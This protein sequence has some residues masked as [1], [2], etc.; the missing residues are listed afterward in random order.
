MRPWPPA[1]GSLAAQIPAE[2]SLA[3]DNYTGTRFAGRPELYLLPNPFYPQCWGDRPQ[4]LL[5]TL[6][7]S[8]PGTPGELRR[9]IDDSSVDYVLT[10]LGGF[11]FPEREADR[12]LILYALL[13]SRRYGVSH[14]DG[15]L[16]LLRR[17]HTWSDHREKLLLREFAPP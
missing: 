14:F 8:R 7:L 3:A 10:R 12:W 2:A 17:G 15:Q 11:S 9:G 16:L 1:W 13:G 6:P 5:E 4:A